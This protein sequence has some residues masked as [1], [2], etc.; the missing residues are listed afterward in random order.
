MKWND[1]IESIARS[2]A[3]KVG[4]VCCVRQSFSTESVLQIYTSTFVPVL[5][6]AATSRLVLLL[7]ISTFLTKSKQGSVMLTVLTWHL[8][9]IHFPTTV[10]WRPWSW[11]RSLRFKVEIVRCNRKFYS[12]SFFFSHFLHIE[13]SFGSCFPAIYDLSKIK[14]QV[15]FSVFLFS[16]SFIGLTN[17]F[18]HFQ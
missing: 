2:V 6:I 11:S 17:I 18:F 10:T 12:N 5:N 9:F 3:R 4:L 15:P 14:H 1:Y 7:H 8:D 16:Y 13:P